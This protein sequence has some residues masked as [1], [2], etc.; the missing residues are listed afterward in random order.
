VNPVIAILLGTLFAGEELSPRVA[1]A[2]AI[3]VAAVIL[4]TRCAPRPA[5]DTTDHD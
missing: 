2:A 4:I 3:I 1:L 5:P